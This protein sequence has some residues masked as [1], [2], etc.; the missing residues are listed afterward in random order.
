[1]TPPFPHQAAATAFFTASVPSRNPFFARRGRSF[2]YRMRPVPVVLRRR[3]FS[4][5]LT[6]GRE[7]KRGEERDEGERRG[8]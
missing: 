7:G 6:E 1:M 3:D 2:M 8:L 5:Q 4:D